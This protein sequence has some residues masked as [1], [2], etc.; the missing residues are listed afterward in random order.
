MR[1]VFFFDEMITPKVITFIYWL[2]LLAVLIAGLSTM[3][4]GFGGFLGGIGIIVFGSVFIRVYCELMIVLFK[5]NDNIRKLADDS[6]P[7]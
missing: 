6:T 1:D 3:F 4:R 2:L 7:V 5:I